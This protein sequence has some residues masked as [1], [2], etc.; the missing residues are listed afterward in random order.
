ME[1]GQLERLLK[2]LTDTLQQGKDFTLDQ[3]PQFVQE[4]LRW[5][6]YEAGFW[7]GV[8]ILIMLLGLL[9]GHIVHNATEGDEDDNLFKWI[10]RIIG[11]LMGILF[12]L[13]NVYT[14]IQI[15]VA[16]RV[17]VLEMVRDLLITH[18]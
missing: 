4:L 3:A 5:K 10:P 9:I 17:V 6:F 12:V 16:P 7:V 2:F 18:R 15:S 1:P 14:M 11:C 13:V 8:G